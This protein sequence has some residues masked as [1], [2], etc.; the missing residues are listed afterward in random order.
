M[1]C[2]VLSVLAVNKKGSSGKWVG[3][4][5]KNDRALCEYFQGFAGKTLEFN[6]M[7]QF[8]VMGQLRPNL[9]SIKQLCSYAV[10]RQLLSTGY[11]NAFARKNIRQT[12]ARCLEQ[13]LY[14][15]P[16]LRDFIAA[17]LTLYQYLHR[18]QHR[19]L[20]YSLFHRQI[21]LAPSISQLLHNPIR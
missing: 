11:T 20:M 2:V 17:R 6:R 14:R 1:L 7:F 19:Q 8:V 4:V 9:F 5:A 18:T 10:F 21:H 3:G 13:L 15:W 16:R 12:N